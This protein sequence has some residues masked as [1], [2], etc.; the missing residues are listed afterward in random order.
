MILLRV[1][2]SSFSLGPA[3][4]AAGPEKALSYSR[5]VRQ[6]AANR[7]SRQALSHRRFSTLGSEDFAVLFGKKVCLRTTFANIRGRGKRRGR[8]RRRTGSA[9]FP[10][11]PAGRTCAAAQAKAGLLRNP[12]V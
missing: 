2:A 10:S 5:A 7:P 12:F 8:K 3:Y 11:R 9:G 6:H 4:N 1:T